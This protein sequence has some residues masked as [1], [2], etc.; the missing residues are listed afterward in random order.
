MDAG[1]P[2]AACNVIFWESQLDGCLNADTSFCKQ[3]MTAL[4]VPSPLVSTDITG[5]GDVC[6]NMVAIQDGVQALFT[7]NLVDMVLELF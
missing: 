5:C 6:Y 4:F 1:T 2:D 7:L 3:A